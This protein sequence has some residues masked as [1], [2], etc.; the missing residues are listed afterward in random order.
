M[1]VR[2]QG[3]PY[4]STPL[5]V[6]NEAGGSLA[7]FNMLA[8][9]KVPR[10]GGVFANEHRIASPFWATVQNGVSNSLGRDEVVPVSDLR[11]KVG[12]ATVPPR[13]ILLRVHCRDYR[14]QASPN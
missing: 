5:G 8:A 14:P 3:N 9:G 7:R 1:R 4:S 2:R 13:W 6:R 12:K 10:Q 11:R